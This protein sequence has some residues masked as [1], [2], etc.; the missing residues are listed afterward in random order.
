[1]RRKK[2][3][4]EWRAEIEDAER[5]SVKRL[6]STPEHYRMWLHTFISDDYVVGKAGLV[7]ACPLR[8]YFASL[9]SK[10]IYVGG[11]AVWSKKWNSNV[12]LPRW[13]MK[14]ALVLDQRVPYG[15]TVTKKVALEILEEIYGSES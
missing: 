13:A 4:E 2:P 9:V 8:N 10:E 5:A 1:M 6:L 14:F 12:S 15:N 7:W 11:D 3:D